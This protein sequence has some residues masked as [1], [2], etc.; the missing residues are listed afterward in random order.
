MKK[1]LLLTLAAGLWAP[2]FAQDTPKSVAGSTCPSP[3]SFQ[4]THLY[5]SWRIELTANGQ[6]GR[7]TLRQHPEFTESLRG[8]LSY[9]STKSIASGDLEEGELNLDESNDRISMTAT[10]TGKLVPSSCG[11]EIRGEW[12]DL[13]KDTRSP[14]ILRRES[15]W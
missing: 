6:T 14:F 10:W 7:L 4:P 15:G 2:A 8:E 13:T 11:K 3:Q 9:G 12:H 5:G 1:A